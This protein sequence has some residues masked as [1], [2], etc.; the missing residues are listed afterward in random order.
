M[1][2]IYLFCR[3][4]PPKL[5]REWTVLFTEG[6]PL[7]EEVGPDE[8]ETDEITA[9]KVLQEECQQLLDETEFMEYKV[10]VFPVYNSMLSLSH[11]L[12]FTM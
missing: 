3:Q 5:V 6:K 2:C 9:D 11:S 12:K 1:K 7:Y 10:R 4:L 8:A